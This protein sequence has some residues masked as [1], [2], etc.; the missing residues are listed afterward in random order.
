MRTM[1]ALLSAGLSEQPREAR[2]Q[3]CLLKGAE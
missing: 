3:A 2:A 1:Y